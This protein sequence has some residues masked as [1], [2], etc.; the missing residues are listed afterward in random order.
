MV[1]FVLVMAK[2]GN[3]SADGTYAMEDVVSVAELEPTEDHG[4]PGLDVG[5]EE[6]ERAVP[7]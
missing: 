2:A 6:D 4:H 5:R 7:D 3:V 1:S